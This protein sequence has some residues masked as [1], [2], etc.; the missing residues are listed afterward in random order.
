MFP[1]FMARIFFALTKGLKRFAHSLARTFHE[2]AD[3]SAK[4]VDRGSG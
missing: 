2:A 4:G 1:N 3:F